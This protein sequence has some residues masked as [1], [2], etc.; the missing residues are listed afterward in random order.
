MPYLYLITGDNIAAFV[1]TT[2]AT[3]LILVVILPSNFNALHALEFLFNF[4]DITVVH[5]THVL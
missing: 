2:V 3:D 4:N 1:A 5:T